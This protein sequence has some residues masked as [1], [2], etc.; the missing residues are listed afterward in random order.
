[1]FTIMIK[2][3]KKKAICIVATS[4]ARIGSRKSEEPIL[5]HKNHKT[6]LMAVFSEQC[7]V[8]FSA[9]LHMMLSTL[10]TCSTTT[11]KSNAYIAHD[12]FQ[13]LRLLSVIEANQ[14]NDGSRYSVNTIAGVGVLNVHPAAESCPKEY[15]QNEGALK[16]RC[17][18]GFLDMKRY[19]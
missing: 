9:Y 2:M 5:S 19:F 17:V 12:F 11:R 13:Q 16:G 7:V 3:K 10:F 14:L 4:A 15:L 6:F 18:P 1:M 8:W